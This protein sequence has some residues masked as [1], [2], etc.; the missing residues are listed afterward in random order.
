M[1]FC[2]LTIFTTAFACF[3]SSFL[4]LG[5]VGKGYILFVFPEGVYDG[6]H[7]GA[8]YSKVGGN[9]HLRFVLVYY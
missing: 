6:G 1:S 5:L 9:F 3:E 4:L 7:C 8:R 2:A